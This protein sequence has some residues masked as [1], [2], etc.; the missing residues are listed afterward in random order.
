MYSIIIINYK[1]PQ[2][3]SECI[4]GLFKVVPSNT[5]IIVVDNASGDD[6]LDI[7]KSNFRN[8]IKLIPSEINLGFAGGNNLGT[9]SATGEYL[10]FLNSDTIIESDFIATCIKI[11]EENKNVGIISP[12]LKLPGGDYQKAAFGYFPTVWKLMTQQTKNE[13]SLNI[14]SF[15]EVGWVSGC[16]LI[17]SRNLF[18]KIG[19]WDDNFF[20]YLEDVDLCRRAHIYHYAC[21]VSQEVKIVHLGGQSTSRNSSKSKYYYISQDY[22]FKKHYGP[23]SMVMVKILRWPYLLYKFLIQ[24]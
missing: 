17:I 15:T 5:E 14:S 13:P 16:A 9:K 4:R 10:I 11:L 24:K 18:D 3:T 20:L 6:S 22:Y 23:L 7:L 19:G 2:L 12:R 8:T 1:T 21:A